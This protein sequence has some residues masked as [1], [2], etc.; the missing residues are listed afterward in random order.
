MF[1]NYSLLK[2]LCKLSFTVFSNEYVIYIKTTSEM[3][4]NNTLLEILCKLSNFFLI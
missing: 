4:I 2:I 1:I 3:Y